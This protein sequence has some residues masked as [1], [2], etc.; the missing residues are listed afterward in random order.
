MATEQV[1]GYYLLGVSDGS[2][3]VALDENA[4]A[5]L[6]R[7]FPVGDWWVA[8]RSDIPLTELFPEAIQ[9]LSPEDLAAFEAELRRRADAY[10]DGPNVAGWATSRDDAVAVFGSPVSES[11]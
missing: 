8:L 1:H 3:L 9:A 11:D 5:A 2:W 6:G 4:N 7:V 10:R